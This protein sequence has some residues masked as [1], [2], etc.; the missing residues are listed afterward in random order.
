MKILFV[1]MFALTGSTV[2]AQQSC[3]EEREGLK[4]QL[5][6]LQAKYD[7]LDERTST[8]PTHVVLQ[9]NQTYWLANNNCKTIFTNGYA[10]QANVGVKVYKKYFCP[11]Y[12]L[13]YAPATDSFLVVKTASLISLG[14]KP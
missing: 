9:G 11:G 12:S 2:F 3:E 1:L 13:V 5:T 8:L 6:D 14:K 4:K 10:L 7:D